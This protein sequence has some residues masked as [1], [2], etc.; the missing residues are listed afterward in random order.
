MANRGEG[1]V[2]QGRDR[3]PGMAQ[4]GGEG[5]RR[6]P[7]QGPGQGQGVDPDEAVRGPGR[8][9]AQAALRLRR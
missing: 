3:A 7:Q 9:P 6:D 2:E 5:E 8:R 1:G 4:N